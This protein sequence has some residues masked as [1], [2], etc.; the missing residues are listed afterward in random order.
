M[1]EVKVAVAGCGTVGS[2]V[3]SLIKQNADV[4]RRRVGKSI[5][6]V[7]VADRNPEKVLRLGISQEKF[8]KDPFELF[9]L[10]ADIY[11]ELMG[12][13]DVAQRFIT[14]ALKRGKGVVTANKALLAERGQGILEALKGGGVLRFEASVGGGIPV[15]KALTEGLVANRINRIVGIINGTAN[16]ILTNMS[17]KGIPFERALDEA[18]ALG[19][20]ESDPSLDVDGYD[21]AH[22]IAI[23]ASLS[24]GRW[25]DI[26]SVFVDGI[27][28]ITPLDIEFAGQFGYSVKLIALAKRSDS[29]VEVR[30]HPAMLPQSHILSSVEGVYNACLVEGDFVGQ[31]LYYGKGAG[32]KPTASAVVADICDIASGRGS[33][34]TNELLG[35]HS[36][37]K[38]KDPQEF[39]S[40]FYL[41]FTAVDKPGVLAKISSI[42]GKHGISIK[43]ALQKDINVDGGVP[44]VLTTHEA[45]METVKRAIGEI[46]KLDVIKKPT[47]VCMIEE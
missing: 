40:N 37:I 33:S 27:R 30:V 2:G 22:K 5:K 1:E 24:F 6:I 39:V 46:D 25:I 38:V 23:L 35:E 12:S 11:V 7:G 29:Q 42:L 16:F 31:T 32:R 47:F 34:L 13:V 4:I 20:A 15:V 9:N 17:K 10:D 18:K 19:Y 26:N 45:K 44:I 21:A 14:E 8:F 41:R 43:M 28:K 3:V 36:D